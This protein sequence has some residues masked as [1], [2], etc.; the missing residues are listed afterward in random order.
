MQ[1]SPPDVPFYIIIKSRM[2]DVYSNTSEKRFHCLSFKIPY[3]FNTASYSPRTKK[4]HQNKLRS[5]DALPHRA[6]T[7]FL[8][9]R[10]HILRHD[11]TKLISRSSQSRE[12][13]VVRG[14]DKP[15]SSAA[16]DYSSI[17]VPLVSVLTADGTQSNM[18]AGPSV[19]CTKLL[20]TVCKIEGIIR[21]N[22]VLRRNH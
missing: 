4:K 9:T 15:N 20:S 12:M 13:K 14:Q 8:L 5:Q 1:T 10:A 16:V 18:S 19:P 22:D 2:P 17:S 11:S 6:Y 3:I 7:G 21:C